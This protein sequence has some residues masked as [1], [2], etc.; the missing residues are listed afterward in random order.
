MMSEKLFLSLAKSST[1]SSERRG[2]RRSGFQPRLLHSGKSHPAAREGKR[3]LNIWVARVSL[4]IIP[5]WFQQESIRFKV[6]IPAGFRRESIKGQLDKVFGI[7][8]HSRVLAR[9]HDS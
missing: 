8:T 6:V 3:F 5:A 9:K 7:F 4:D 1:L 2:R